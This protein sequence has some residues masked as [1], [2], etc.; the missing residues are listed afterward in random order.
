MKIN[1]R[2]V[3]R[4]DPQLK[5]LAKQISAITDYDDLRAAKKAS[6]NLRKTLD[7]LEDYSNQKVMHKS[8]NKAVDSYKGTNWNH[9]TIPSWDNYSRKIWEAD[10]S[11][12]WEKYAKILLAV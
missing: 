9:Y 11:A 4:L 1:L 5:N 10:N 6:K 2:I 3:R 7:T 8:F 12:Y